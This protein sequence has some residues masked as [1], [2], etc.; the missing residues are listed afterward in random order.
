MDFLKE[1]SNVETMIQTLINWHT[2]DRDRRVVAVEESFHLQVDIAEENDAVEIR[3]MIDRIEAAS[4]DAS[5]IH[6]VDLKT[7]KKAPSA[8]KTLTDPQLAAYRM[9][10]DKGAL[11]ELLPK[12]AKAVGAELVQLRDTAK[13][14]A[15]VLNSAPVEM[16]GINDLL[17]AIKVI[18]DESVTATICNSC[19]ICAYKKICPAQ[20]EGQSVI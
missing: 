9:A 8:P 15:R 18:R 12:D 5:A 3:G 19:R 6:I 7:S 1:K 4:D 17:K 2:A 16:S 13:G 11:G 20:S 10:V 14:K